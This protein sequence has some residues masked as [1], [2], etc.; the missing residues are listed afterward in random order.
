MPDFS[1]ATIELGNCTKVYLTLDL[2]HQHSIEDITNKYEELYD[3]LHSNSVKVVYEKAF[4]KISNKSEYLQL[5]SAM[6][7]KYRFPLFPNTY[8]EGASVGDSIIAGVTI[9]GVMYAEDAEGDF[10]YLKSRQ[11]HNLVG[12]VYTINGIRHMNLNGIHG[13]AKE[14]DTEQELASM[15]ELAGEHLANNNFTAQDVVRTWIYLDDI[16]HNYQQFNAMRNQYFEKNAI[17]YSP[18]SK[19][20]PASTCIGGKTAHDKT[21]CLD[22]LCI[23]RN[24]HE[25][26]IERLFN[27]LQNEADGDAY[28]FK[29]AFARGVRIENAGCAEVQISGTASINERGETLHPNDAYSQITRTLQNI[30]KLLAN[31]GMQFKDVCQSTCYFKN[32][33]YYACFL[34]AMRDLCIDSFPCNYLV[35]DICRS[36]LLFELDG[37]AVKPMR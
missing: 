36:D 14:P 32:K 18:N 2:C 19:M 20:L 4:G 12:A 17:D 8:L 5:R 23:D 22:V 21:G 1:V 13:T 15:Y 9:Y 30:A 6:A 28:L 33:E 27:E 3:F 11:D 37:I 10:K 35:C 26:K 25:L 31:A 16:D 34:K 24:H 29:P 7:E